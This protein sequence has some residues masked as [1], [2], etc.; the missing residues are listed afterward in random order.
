MVSGFR[1]RNRPAGFLFQDDRAGGGFPLTRRGSPNLPGS[2]AL[3]RQRLLERA[4][5]FQAVSAAT[6]F[7]VQAASSCAAPAHCTMQRF[8]RSAVRITRCAATP[9]PRGR[10]RPLLRPAPGKRP[11]RS[12]GRRS[13]R[14]GGRSSRPVQTAP[15]AVPLTWRSR[16]KP[17]SKRLQPADG[18]DHR[19]PAT[20]LAKQS[21]MTA[22]SAH[23]L[24][25]ADARTR[26][27]RAAAHNRRGW[28]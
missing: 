6:R 17:W 25:A 4:P 9:C 26:C 1:W 23:L 20:Q 11:S 27:R 7:A 28:R 21:R 5:G 16:W 8:S 10:R 13:R 18:G 24:I 22:R 15:T 3:A 12:G 2:P 14:P 19:V